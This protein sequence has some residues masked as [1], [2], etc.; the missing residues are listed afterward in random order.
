MKKSIGTFG[1]LSRC[2]RRPSR[3]LRRRPAASAAT[4]PS[5]S[6]TER[7]GGARRPDDLSSH[8]LRGGG[9]DVTVAYGTANGTATAG[10]DYITASGTI[11]FPPGSTAAE[12]RVTIAADGLDEPDETF[13]LNLSN[14]VGA[15]LG[16]GAGDRDDRGR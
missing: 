4:R 9:Q 11:T 5:A 16:D 14:P 1:A 15:V 7:A 13:A 2:V 6:R 12:V 10:D 3:P 8:A